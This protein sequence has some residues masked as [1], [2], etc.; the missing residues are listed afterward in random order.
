MQNGFGR[1]RFFF[2][3]SAFK[4][5]IWTKSKNIIQRVRKK[6]ASNGSEFAVSNRKNAKDRKRFFGTI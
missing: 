3:D 5:L 2:S 6:T 1:K 4:K